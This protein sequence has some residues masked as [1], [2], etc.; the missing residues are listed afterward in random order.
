MIPS[1]AYQAT[2]ITGE[3]LDLSRPLR[4]VECQVEGQDAAFRADHHRPGD[5]GFDAPPAEYW[6][7]SSLGQVAT[8]LGVEPTPALRLVA[9]AD[10][11]LAAAYRG[12]CPDVDPDALMRW[13]AE[14]RAQFQ[15]VVPVAPR[16]WGET[17][18]IRKEPWSQ[19]Y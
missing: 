2:G 15:A 1:R 16:V 8:H 19:L 13:R 18:P 9:A 4:L 14:T 17:P 6:R 7:G 3:P 12:A 11:C 5:P 10:H